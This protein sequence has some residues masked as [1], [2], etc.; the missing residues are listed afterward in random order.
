MPD[1]PTLK[2]DRLLLRQFRLS[3]AKAVQRLAGA[4]EIAAT[5][6]VP[7]PYEDGMAEAWIE[8]QKKDFAAG[9]GINFALVL[10]EEDVL[11]GVI[12]LEIDRQHRRAQL[13]YWIGVPYWNQGYCTEAVRVVLGYGF[14]ELGL[15]RIWA[16]HFKSNPASGRVLQKAGMKY[17]GCQREHYVRFDRYE[18]SE[19]YGLLKREYDAS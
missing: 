18:D 8:D 6:F 10:A 7:H 16:P 14:G 15:Q 5:T 4:K 19:L 12:G 11:I 9:T 17:E 1:F 2:T 13:G 3:D